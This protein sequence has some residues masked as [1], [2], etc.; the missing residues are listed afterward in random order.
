MKSNLSSF[1]FVVCAFSAISKKPLPNPRA[2][3]FTPMFLS[4]SSIALALTFRTVVYLD[5]I[6]LY[7]V[8]VGCNYILL[9]VHVQFSPHQLLKISLN[10]LGILVQNQ[11][12]INVWVYSRTLESNL[13]MYKSIFMPVPQCLEYWCFIISFEIRKCEFSTFVLLF[14]HCF[15]YF[16]PLVF[17]YGF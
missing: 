9:Y 1:S 4:K 8:E 11:L 7:G 6:F 2:Q 10:C 13:S 14:Q 15:G 12:S 5:L 3:R 16:G 17:L